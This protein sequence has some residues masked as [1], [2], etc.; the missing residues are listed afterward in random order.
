MNCGEDCSAA[1]VS[2]DRIKDESFELTNLV[3]MLIT[4]GR[5]WEQLYVAI[6]AMR[7]MLPPPESDGRVRSF[8]AW[9]RWA[10]WYLDIDDFEESTGRK[11]WRNK[12]HRACKELPTTGT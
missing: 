5:R 12:E 3:V 6:E 9:I 4:L 2:D 8:N 1:I 7:Y 11:S 10:R